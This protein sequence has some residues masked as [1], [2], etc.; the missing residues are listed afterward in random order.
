MLLKKLD[1]E[2]INKFVAFYE[3]P[4]INK[5]YLV[6]EHAGSK[7]LADFVSEHVVEDKKLSEETVR[8]VMMQLF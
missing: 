5:T 2:Y 6:L 1:C 4:V 8:S 3:D 7:S